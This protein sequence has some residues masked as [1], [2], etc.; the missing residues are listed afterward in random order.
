MLSRRLTKGAWDHTFLATPP[1]AAHFGSH[2][3]NPDH[4]R[5]AGES[6]DVQTLAILVATSSSWARLVKP[7]V[8]P[9]MQSS[10]TAC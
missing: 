7:M 5:L 9:S 4:P 1:A 2:G 3:R 8:K 10:R 6:A